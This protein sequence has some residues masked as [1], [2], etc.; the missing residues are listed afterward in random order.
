MGAD[1]GFAVGCGIAATLS[2]GEGFTS[3]DA[4]DP[5]KRS[6]FSLMNWSGPLRRYPDSPD[7]MPWLE[8]ARVTQAL[9]CHKSVEAG[10]AA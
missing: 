3:P 10:G 5:P 1:M 8:A 7:I 6:P 4:K 9:G 2:A